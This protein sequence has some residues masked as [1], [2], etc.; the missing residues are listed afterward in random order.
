MRA[1]I[2]LA[3]CLL[4]AC[5]CSGLPGCQQ[6]AASSGRIASASFG[7]ADDAESSLTARESEPAVSTAWPMFRGNPQ[8]TGVATSPL[9]D[10]LALV[11]TY[12]ADK[13]DAFESSAAIVDGVV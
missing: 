7:N 11:W 9:P 10:Q 12:E 5:A 1:L 4:L 2:R 8:L 13:N 6:S 3:H